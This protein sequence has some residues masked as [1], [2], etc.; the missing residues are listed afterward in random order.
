MLQL[1]DKDFKQLKESMII[2][3]K[4]MRNLRRA[5]ETLKRNKYDFRAKN[6]TT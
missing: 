4:Q 3:K 1:A 2:M 5:M 6:Y